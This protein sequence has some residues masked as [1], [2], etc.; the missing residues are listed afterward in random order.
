[1]KTN[2]IDLL[3]S[4]KRRVSYEYGL[5]DSKG[6]M[7]ELVD[8]EDGKIDFDSTRTV[9]RSFSGTARKSDVLSGSFLDRRLIPWMCVMDGDITIERIPLGTFIINP[10]ET[11]ENGYG[12][13]NISGY[14]YGKIALDDRVTSRFYVRAGE[15]YTNVITGILTELYLN[16]EVEASL[17]TKNSM[18]EYSIGT[19]KIDIINNLLTAINYNP[20]HFN[21]TGTPIADKY[22][23]PELREIEML[24]SDDNNSII[25]DTV[26]VDTNKFDIPNKFVRYTEDPDSLYRISV[27]VNEDPNNEYST[28]ARGRTIVSS[29]SVKDIASQAELDEYTKRVALQSMAAVETISF[30]SLNM[31]YHEYRNCML[32]NISTYGIS[33]KYIETAWSMDLKSGIMTHKVQKAVRL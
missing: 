18:A 28:V 33:G 19:T 12:T 8:I 17:S 24:Y 1:M 16:N 26:S 2:I 15:S 14:D 10:S 30:K 4:D 23:E 32:L 22:I 25:V 13:V 7:I 6:N 9:M 27:Y 5:A 31:P 20:L 29:A 3:K 11:Y 21:S